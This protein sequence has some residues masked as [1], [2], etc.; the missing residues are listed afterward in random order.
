MMGGGQAGGPVPRGAGGLASATYGRYHLFV[1]I[2][3]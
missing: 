1:L 3:H 2:V